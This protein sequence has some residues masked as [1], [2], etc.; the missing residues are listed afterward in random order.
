MRFFYPNHK[1]MFRTGVVR[2]GIVVAVSLL[3]TSCAES[4]I[5]QCKKLIDVANQV[6]TNVQSVAQN[7]SSTTG[8]VANNTDSFAVIKWQRQQTQQRVT[9]KHSS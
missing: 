3:A 6:V 9:W 8:A 4:K 5:S 7:A 1:Q 2:T